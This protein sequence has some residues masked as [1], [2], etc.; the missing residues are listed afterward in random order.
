METQWLPWLLAPHA[1]HLLDEER[2]LVLSTRKET[3]RP[4][5]NIGNVSSHSVATPS[6]PSPAAGPRRLPQPPSQS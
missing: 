6:F 5:R 2:P 1:T 4:G 3:D